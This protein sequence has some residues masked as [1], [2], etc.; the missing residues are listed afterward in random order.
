MQGG[1]SQASLRTRLYSFKN[2]CRVAAAVGCSESSPG[3]QSDATV[4]TQACAH[5][6]VDVKKEALTSDGAA[7][8]T[9]PALTAA[10]TRQVFLNEYK[11]VLKE[12]CD[13]PPCILRLLL[14]K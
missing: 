3:V 1:T 2:T 8:A 14:F 9:S 11:R 7:S 12:A 10:A 4:A 5:A 13:V 6:G